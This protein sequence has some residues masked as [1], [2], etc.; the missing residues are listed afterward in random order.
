MACSPMK[1][2][3]YN[4]PVVATAYAMPSSAGGAHED[5]RNVRS[6]VER[7]PGGEGVVAQSTAESGASGA[8]FEQED[9]VSKVLRDGLLLEIIL[10]KL[11][12]DVSSR[13]AASEVCS[14]WYFLDGKIRREVTVAN[15]YSAYPPRLTERFA[16]LKSIKLKCRPRAVEFQQLIADWGGCAREWVD[17][18]AA[19]YRKLESLHLK[20]AVVTDADLERIGEGCGNFL[21]QLILDK[22]DGFSAA[23]LLSIG[24]R[25]RC[26]F[27]FPLSRG[28]VATCHFLDKI[29][30]CVAPPSSLLPVPC[31]F[32]TVDRWFIGV[33]RVW[34]RRIGALT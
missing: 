12:H 19:K 13:H 32:R 11:E 8:E 26:P 10:R 7:H 17:E 33:S 16:D 3:L 28:L 23:G 34:R 20:R 29:P 15:C 21:R 30:G 4:S 6:R 31:H 1:M 9:A 2:V 14:A 24:G 5:L 27:S 25:C 18:I 22:C